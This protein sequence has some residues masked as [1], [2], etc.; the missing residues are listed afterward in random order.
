MPVGSLRDPRA[1]R[2][3]PSCP[4]GATSATSASGPRC[5]PG[6]I[7]SRTNRCLS[8]LQ[9]GRQQAPPHRAPRCP[10]PGPTNQQASATPRPGCEPYPDVLLDHLVDQHPGPE[11]RYETTKALLPGLHRRPAAAAPAPARRARP[12]RR[13]GLPR[14]RSRPDARHHPGSRKQR[15]RRHTAST[16]ASPT[17]AAPAPAAAGLHAQRGAAA[18]RR[19]RRAHRRHGTRRPGRPDRT[20]RSRRGDAVARAVPGIRGTESAR[21]LLAAVTFAR[22]ASWYP[23]R[24]R[25]ARLRPVLAD[26]HASVYRAYS[27]LVI[28]TAG[29]R[30][31]AITGSPTSWSTSTARTLPK[32][33][34]RP[35]RAAR[36]RCR[37]RP[38][39]RPPHPGLR[40]QPGHGP[41]GRGKS[42]IRPAA[43]PPSARRPHKSPAVPCS[44]PCRP[45]PACTVPPQSW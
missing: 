9:P 42:A 41:V 22:H 14:R 33:T 38:P 29:D 40:G 13:P 34:D 28:A 21:R 5:E 4:P 11:A 26:P 3:R 37:G 16:T 2:K 25:P 19:R 10:G 35:L 15:T 23:P 7:R 18:G 32:Q 6:C 20:A 24:Q 8:M 12:P 17:P 30:I 31:A 39:R 27:L 36:R 45:R 44:V 1:L 43:W